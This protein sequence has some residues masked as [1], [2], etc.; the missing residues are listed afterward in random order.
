MGRD[1]LQTLRHSLNDV[2]NPA[3]RNKFQA[4]HI[5]FDKNSTECMNHQLNDLSAPI[6]FVI[7]CSRMPL[8]SFI[9]AQTYSETHVMS[10]QFVNS[11]I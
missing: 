7:F 6:N 9:S 1:D 3:S 10:I 4:L 5:K 8:T 2:S 11:E